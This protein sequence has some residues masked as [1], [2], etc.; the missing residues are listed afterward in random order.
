MTNVI[1]ERGQPYLGLEFLSRLGLDLDLDL[2]LE[3]QIGLEIGLESG[4]ELGFESGLRTA[5]ILMLVL[6]DPLNRTYSRVRLYSQIKD[7]LIESSQSSHFN[8]I[9]LTI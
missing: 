3:L 1:G 9:T 7:L 6:L 5:R 2:D 4:L 8:H